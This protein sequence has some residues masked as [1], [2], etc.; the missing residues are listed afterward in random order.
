MKSFLDSLPGGFPKD[1][2]LPL[3]FTF[4]FPCSQTA[5]AAAQLHHWTKV[6]YN[7]IKKL[8]LLIYLIIEWFLYFFIGFQV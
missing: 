6:N 3:G 5:L 2:C 1:L 7:S 4:S 8:R